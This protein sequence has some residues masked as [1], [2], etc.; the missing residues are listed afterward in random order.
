MAKKK[1][2]G[3]ERAEREARL[4]QMRLNAERTRRLAERAQAQLD[5]KTSQ[6]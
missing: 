1:P 3:A 5:A 2:T 4:A 6:G